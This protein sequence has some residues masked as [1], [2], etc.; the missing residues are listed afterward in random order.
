MTRLRG[1]IFACG[2]AMAGAA[3][4]VAGCSSSSSPAAAGNEAG[5][6]ASVATGEAGAEGGA[7]AGADSSLTLQWKV[8]LFNTPASEIAGDSGSTDGG[9]GDATS[10]ASSDA[11]DGGDGAAPP[12][13]G[14]QV[15][16]YQNSTF[17]CVTTQADGTFTMT[18]LPLRTNLALT[19]TKSGYLSYL[20]PFTTASANMDGRDLPQQMAPATGDYYAPTGLA[21]A[22]DSQT[23]GQIQAFAVDLSSLP[24]AD[25]GTGFRGAPNTSVTLSPMSGN[26][27]FFLNN[28][29]Q[30]D[31]SATTFESINATYFNIAPGTYTLTYANPNYDCEPVNFPFAR[32]GWPLMTPA[33]S[34]QIVVAAGYITGIVG[35]VCSKSAAIVSMDG[36]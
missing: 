36:G 17:P 32:D 18:G 19:F 16:L 15:C 10:D 30:Y 33:H 34:V 3:M 24:A 7:D 31:L 22:V 26:G 8:T 21:F 23:K 1:V 25:S 20:R 9:A 14:V 11:G 2:A 12:L 35:T 27:P 5:A 4:V 6:E 28:Q 13:P 29:F